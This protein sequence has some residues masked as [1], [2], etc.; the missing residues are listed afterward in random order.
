M[1][2]YELWCWAFGHKFREKRW[3]QQDQWQWVWY[4]IVIV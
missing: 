1:G 3:N 4:G 2:L